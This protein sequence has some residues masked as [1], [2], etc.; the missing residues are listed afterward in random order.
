MEV[1]NQRLWLTTQ[2]PMAEKGQNKL[3][4]LLILYSFTVRV[5]VNHQPYEEFNIEVKKMKKGDWIKASICFGLRENF[6]SKF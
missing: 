5:K 4:Y 1:V 2:P 3:I 6:T